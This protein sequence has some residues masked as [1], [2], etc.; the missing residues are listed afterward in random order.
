[1]QPTPHQ[2]PAG[3]DERLAVAY[4][5]APRVAAEKASGACASPR[6]MIGSSGSL[7]NCA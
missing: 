1:M 3:A 2:L 5:L 7:S 4:L 6:P